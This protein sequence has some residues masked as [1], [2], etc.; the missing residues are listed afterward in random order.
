MSISPQVGQPTIAQL[1]PSS[2]KADQIP[3]PEGI[4]MLASSSP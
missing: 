3:R 4:L 2:Q 1:L